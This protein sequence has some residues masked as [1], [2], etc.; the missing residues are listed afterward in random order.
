MDQQ[1]C[2]SC[3]VVAPL[4]AVAIWRGMLINYERGLPLNTP[5]ADEDRFRMIASLNCYQAQLD[6]APITR[7]AAAR[8][9]IHMSAAP[10]NVR[11]F[12]EAI[13]SHFMLRMSQEAF[14]LRLL[15]T[16]AMA[17]GWHASEIGRVRVTPLAIQRIGPKS[18]SLQLHPMWSGFEAGYAE[19]LELQLILSEERVHAPSYL[20]LIDPDDFAPRGSILQ[21]TVTPDGDIGPGPLDSE[22]QEKRQGEFDV[23]IGPDGWPDVII[24]ESTETSVW[25]I[26]V[27]Y[28]VNYAEVSEVLDLCRGGKGP[29][30]LTHIWM[31]QAKTGGVVFPSVPTTSDTCTNFVTCSLPSNPEGD[32]C[33]VGKDGHDTMLYSLNSLATEAI[34]VNDFGH[35]YAP[36][37]WNIDVEPA[38]SWVSLRTAL[39]YGPVV[40][41][42]DVTEEFTSLRSNNATNE[43][44]PF[45]IRSDSRSLG[46]HEVTVVGYHASPNG[47][48]LSYLIIQN[49]WGCEWGSCGVAYIR[50]DCC[51]L[52]T[53]YMPLVR[54]ES[55][56]LNPLLPPLDNIRFRVSPDTVEVVHQDCTFD[57]FIP[58][59]S[60]VQTCKSTENII[61]YLVTWRDTTVFVPF[62]ENRGYQIWYDQG[63]PNAQFRKVTLT[64][65]TW[66]FRFAYQYYNLEASVHSV[67]A[68]IQQDQT[69]YRNSVLRKPPT[70]ARP[71]GAF[72]LSAY[73]GSTEGPRISIFSTPL[74]TQLV[75]T[76]H[77]AP[78]KTHGDLLMLPLATLPDVYETQVTFTLPS[79]SSGVVAERS[80]LILHLDPATTDAHVLQPPIC[81][82]RNP[83]TNTIERGICVTTDD[84]TLVYTGYRIN[85][86]DEVPVPWLDD[87][88]ETH[89]DHLLSPLTCCV[90]MVS[91]PTGTPGFAVT[92]IE[93]SDLAVDSLRGVYRETADEDGGSANI[94]AIAVGATVALC[95]CV[96]IVAFVALRVGLS[97]RSKK[98]AAHPLS[99]G[100]TVALTAPPL[101]AGA[102]GGGSRRTSQRKMRRA[103]VSLGSHTAPTSPVYQQPSGV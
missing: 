12:A 58:H 102:A 93:F 87:S 83:T 2:N 23:N 45:F 20:V 28:Y 65:R 78:A 82:A 101:G 38:K 90:G 1:D 67:D 96:A 70:S 48:R 39:S 68:D 73:V 10:R 9:E 63:L 54:L 62:Q 72:G 84:C 26:M 24:P 86:K 46:A 81:H 3:Y 33:P 75:G 36:I 5:L 7:Q 34:D 99:T 6:T 18:F 57:R 11:F 100:R 77:W 98:R 29:T 44:L 19:V 94:V 37:F 35:G 27:P 47:Q 22:Q 88:C 66:D 25:P 61:D 31:M 56:V 97:M 40:M 13:E 55:Q 64:L 85:P 52:R 17:N 8:V 79:V 69:N 21:L 4:T 80:T 14:V 76:H 16:V 32:L 92:S 42:L 15:E 95:C 74:G 89:S 51:G 103:S 49:S 30:T 91:P 41:V 50:P 71:L 59:S 53:P 43:R 60:V